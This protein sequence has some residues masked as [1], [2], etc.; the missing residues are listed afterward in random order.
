V[1]TLEDQVAFQARG[2]ALDLMALPAR[3]DELGV[4]FAQGVG[5]NGRPLLLLFPS[6]GRG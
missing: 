1:R 4:V 5:N 2:F 6:R 3:S